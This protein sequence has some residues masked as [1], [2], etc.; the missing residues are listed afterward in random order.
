MKQERGSC[1]VVIQSFWS[2]KRSKVKACE[3]YDYILEESSRTG[4]MLWPLFKFIQTNLYKL[5][6]P[7]C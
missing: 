2:G 5:A 4:A 1:E 7:K 3:D 6:W